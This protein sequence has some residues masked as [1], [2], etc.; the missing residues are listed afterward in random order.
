MGSYKDDYTIA[1][2]TVPGIRYDHGNDFYLLETDDFGRKLYWGDEPA[3]LYDNYYLRMLIIVQFS[4]DE[5]V[6]YYD[7]VCYL[8]CPFLS[9]DIN[10]ID[11]DGDYKTKVATFVSEYIP[12]DELTEF[13]KQND[14]GKEL[15]ADKCTKKS[16][17]TYRS[18]PVSQQD[19]ADILGTAIPGE[20]NTAIYLSEYTG[21]DLYFV[22]NQDG[23]YSEA[24]ANYIV[25]IK[26]RQL[27]QYEEIPD[28]F[29]CNDLIREFKQQLE[30]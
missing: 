3:L 26:D 8:Q 5:E 23:G 16:L 2:S 28:R 12:E 30:I 10:S 19:M 6:G 18:Y 17:I 27:V 1:V 4:D 7:D 29:H 24:S 13:K 22:M 9:G 14:W 21:Y 15:S 11:T 20:K 25:A